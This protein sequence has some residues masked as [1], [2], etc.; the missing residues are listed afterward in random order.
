MKTILLA[1]LVAMLMAVSTAFADDPHSAQP[2][3]GAEGPDV[4]HTV[5]QP[6]IHLDDWVGSS[7]R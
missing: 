7:I 5:I 1:T 4:R 2:I 3:K 6:Q